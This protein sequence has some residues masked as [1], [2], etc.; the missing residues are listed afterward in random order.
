MNLVNP[1]LP[2]C[3]SRRDKSVATKNASIGVRTKPHAPPEFSPLRAREVHAPPPDHRPP[4]PEYPPSPP[5][6]V[7]GNSPGLGQLARVNSVSQLG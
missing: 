3:S 6:T 7:A 4:P 5:L 2:S 1:R